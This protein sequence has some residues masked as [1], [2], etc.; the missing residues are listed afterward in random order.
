MGKRM[1]TVVRL[2]TTTWFSKGAMHIK[3][4]LKSMRRKSTDG[5]CLLELDADATDA[6]EVANRITNLN[7]CDDGLYTVET[8]NESRDWET[9]H[10]DD[11]DY[12]L[13]PYKEESHEVLKGH[14]QMV[15]DSSQDS[16]PSPGLHPA[17]LSSSLGHLLEDPDGL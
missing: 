14:G 1:V 11:Y 12:L 17:R 13:V 16:Q 6:V 4:T 9:G 15:E 3:R 10:V 5:F 7:E 8:C 2:T